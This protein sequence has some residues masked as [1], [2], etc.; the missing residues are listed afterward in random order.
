MSLFGEVKQ[1]RCKFTQHDGKK[2][3]VLGSLYL[4]KQFKYL[5]IILLGLSIL[6]CGS[7]SQDKTS[8]SSPKSSQTQ[9]KPNTTPIQSTPEFIEQIQNLA[10][11]KKYGFYL[12]SKWALSSS[13]YGPGKH[14]NYNYNSS[15]SMGME[16]VIKNGSTAETISLS[17]SNPERALEFVQIF[18]KD[19]DNNK[20]KSYINE[21]LNKSINQIY[22]TIPFVHEGHEIYAGSI[23]YGNT[24]SVKPNSGYSQIPKENELGK[25]DSYNLIN[26]MV[27]Q[28]FIKNLDKSVKEEQLSKKYP[29]LSAYQED[30]NI[31][32]LTDIYLFYEGLNDGPIYDRPGAKVYGAR[33]LGRVNFLRGSVKAK[34]IAHKEL[35]GG[36]NYF[37]VITRDLQGWMGRPYI[38]S[39]KRGDEFFMPNPLTGESVRKALKISNTQVKKV[40]KSSY[41]EFIPSYESILWDNRIPERYRREGYD[42]YVN[43]LREGY[44]QHESLVNSY[45][46]G[47]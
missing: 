45:L 18:F 11:Y 38:M 20:L 30:Y 13:Y 46:G 35:E 34:V 8:K 26:K 7:D 28:E 41:N 24:L 32:P 1:L 2:L 40:F 10:F 23:Y 27:S 17:N 21:N 42:V 44:R 3:W 4:L 19:I 22:Q 36:R 6:S 33:E 9:K 16:V 39:N 14:M 37:Y 47:N 25:K 5:L 15:S 43:A 29:I 12:D 31:L